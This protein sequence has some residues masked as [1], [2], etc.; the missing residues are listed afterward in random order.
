MKPDKKSHEKSLEPESKDEYWMQRALLLAQ[1]AEEE[2]EVPVGAIVVLDN[3]VVG[4]GW[5][6]P[7]S[8]HDPSSH[9]EINAIRE[10]SSHLSNYRLPTTELFVTLEPCVMCAGAMIHARI[11]RVVFGAYDLKAGAAGS[12]F[13][14]LPTAKLNHQVE[15]KGGVLNQACAEILQSFFK[16]RR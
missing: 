13:N 16:K 4:E 15:I 10:A 11:A 3:E 7:I 9:A 5:N 1:K 8:S 14:I 12:V 2:G 6:R